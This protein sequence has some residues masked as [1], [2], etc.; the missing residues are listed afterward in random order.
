MDYQFEIFKDID[1]QYRFR[2][3][4]PNGEIILISEAYT[5]KH[6]ALNTINS[7]KKHASNAPIKGKFL[8][9]KG[10]N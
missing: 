4:A 3:R 2:L 10:E 8:A 6:N 7:I 9:K 5:Q 1:K